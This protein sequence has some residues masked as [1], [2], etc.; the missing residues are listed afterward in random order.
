M[1]D[2]NAM[3]VRS[4]ENLDSHD[5]R[6]EARKI[7]CVLDHGFSIHTLCGLLVTN[8]KKPDATIEVKVVSNGE[9]V[10]SMRVF[11]SQEDSE[12]IWCPGCDSHLGPSW[13]VSFTSKKEPPIHGNMSPFSYTETTRRCENC[14]NVKKIRVFRQP[15]AEEHD[16]VVDGYYCGLNDCPI[17]PEH[18]KEGSIW[19]LIAEGWNSWKVSPDH[20]CDL[21]SRKGWA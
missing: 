21:H 13:Y 16:A 7:H 3:E 12:H 4:D 11:A 9:P 6:C 8:M 2:G 19:H 14:S 18:Q 15:L 10:T 17:T 1:N 5:M 20:S